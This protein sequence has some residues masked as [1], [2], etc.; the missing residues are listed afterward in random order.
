M[1][2][3][4]ESWLLAD[5]EAL[6]AELRKRYVARRLPAPKTIETLTKAK[7]NTLMKAVSSGSYDKGSHS[8]KILAR[9]RPTALRQL[10]W[11]ERFLDA[12]G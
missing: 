12:V 2:V 7:I 4:M 3:T 9:V 8:F 1:C 11:A 6:K 5:G 10:S